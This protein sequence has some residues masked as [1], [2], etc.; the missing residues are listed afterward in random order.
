MAAIDPRN[1]IKV[2]IDEFGEP[3]TE[4][5][6]SEKELAA[7]IIGKNWQT[8]SHILVLTNSITCADRYNETQNEQHH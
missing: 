2:L 4:A 1:V 8:C 7:M 3:G 6:V 5:N